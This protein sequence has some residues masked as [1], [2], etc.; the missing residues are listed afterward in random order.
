MQEDIKKV[1]TLIKAPKKAPIYLAQ[2]F[3]HVVL[4]QSARI[5]VQ[6]IAL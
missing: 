2:R 3:G 5:K 6:R 1:H 4:H